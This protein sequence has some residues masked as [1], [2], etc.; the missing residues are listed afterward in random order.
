MSMTVVVPNDVES[1]VHSMVTSG[2]YVTAS[3][4]VGDAL[5]RMSHEADASEEIAA[6]GNFC[7][8]RDLGDER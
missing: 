2:A 8:P 6:S 4:L 3:E 7:G 5:R 1:F